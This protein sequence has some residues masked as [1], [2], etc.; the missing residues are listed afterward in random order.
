M[1]NFKVG[2]EFAF[3]QFEKVKSFLYFYQIFASSL[4]IITYY[5]VFSNNTEYGQF[6]LIQYIQKFTL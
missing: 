2:F 3:L 5:S 1:A 4:N 6:Y